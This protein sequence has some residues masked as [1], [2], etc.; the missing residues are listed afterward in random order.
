[1][2]A[3][4]AEPS[5]ELLIQTACLLE[6]SARKPGNVHPAASFADLIFS[7]FVTSA[8]VV[9][10]ILAR[11][12]ELGV[13]AAIHAAAAETRQTVGRNTNLGMILLLAPLAA[14]PPA[15]SLKAGIG[16]VL[17]GLDETDAAH[18]Y[19]AIRVANPGGM[20]RVDREDVSQEPTI[21]LVEAMRLAADRDL[22]ALQYVTGFQLVLGSGLEYLAGC[23][24]F[25]VEWEQAII[26]LQLTLLAQ[27]PDSLIARKCGID[28]ARSASSRAGD[29]LAAGWPLTP[30]GADRLAEFD[31]WLRGDGHR[32]NPGTTA[33][34]V[35]ACLFAALRERRIPV[36]D[37]NIRNPGS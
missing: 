11:S 31:V 35:A 5:L 10:P 6:A 34:L 4:P 2:P 12:R 20:G 18:V 9:A 24:H 17:A 8:A 25:H 22:I 26:G 33:D 7:D 36:P 27:H 16:T 37:V 23:S 1:M 14:V 3:A 28:V 13:G 21:P 32:R 19:R 30:A 29:V 15:V